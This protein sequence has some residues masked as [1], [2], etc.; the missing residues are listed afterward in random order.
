MTTSRE[1]GRRGFGASTRWLPGA[2]LVVVLALGFAACGKA[3]QTASTPAAPA[4]SPV[5]RGQYLVTTAG[6]NDC[7]TPFQ[8]GPQGPEPDMSRMLSGHPQG[9]V[10]P[11]P[12]VLPPGPWA[13]VGAGTMTAFAGPFGVSFSANITPDMATGIGSWTEEVFIQTLRSGKHLGTGR[14]ILPPMPWMWVGKMT[15][16]DLKAVYAYLKSIPPIANE[17]PQPIPPKS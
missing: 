10:M 4:M 2:G 8:L 17:V 6:C 16:E 11:E 5:E 9:L 12:P 3:P 15:D 14:Q 1:Q 7:H 13:W